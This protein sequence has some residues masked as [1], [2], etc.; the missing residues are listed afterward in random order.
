[1]KSTKPMVL[2]PIQKYESSKEAIELLSGNPN[3]P[4]KL[5]EERREID[6]GLYITFKSFK[7]K[8]KVEVVK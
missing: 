2:I 3:L 7:K 5:R 4:K 6:N 1:M 8:Y